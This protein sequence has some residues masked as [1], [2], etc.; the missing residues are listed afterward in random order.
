MDEL[1]KISLPILLGCLSGMVAAYFAVKLEFKKLEKVFDLKVKELQK[2]VDIQQ[3]AEIKREAS[4]L[5]LKYVNPLR[6]SA[7]DLRLRLSAIAGKIENQRDCEEMEGWFNHVKSGRNN[8][9]EFALWCNGVGHFAMTTLHLTAVYLARAAKLRVEAPFREVNADYHQQML[10]CLENVRQQ[11]GGRYGLWQESQDSIGERVIKDG[12]GV[13]SYK[14]FCSKLA[15]DAEYPW[16]SRLVD[17]YR[18]IHLKRTD[19]TQVADALQR[20]HD[21][22]S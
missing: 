11:L 6:V 13:I 4:R 18:D 9:D 5:R 22:L 15:D 20:L 19:I 1:I 16:F 8:K 12:D 7:Q 14:E 21:C 2:Q 3:E 17:F 10:E